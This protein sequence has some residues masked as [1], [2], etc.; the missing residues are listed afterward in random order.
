LTY[1]FSYWYEDFGSEDWT[2]QGVEPDTVGS[3]LSLGND[4]NN[5]DAHVFYLGVRY[6][7]GVD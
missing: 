5:Y 7:Y 4:P 1:K 3:L 6:E 2:L